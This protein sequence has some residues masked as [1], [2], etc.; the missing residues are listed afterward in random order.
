MG[1]PGPKPIQVDWTEVQALA[2][3]G[4][5]Q[6]EIASLLGVGLRTLQRRKE[7]DVVYGRGIDSMRKSLRHKQFEL[8]MNGDRS[9]LIWLGKQQLNQTDK[10]ESKVEVDMR[11]R[12]TTELIE[13][14]CNGG[15]K[16]V[17]RLSDVQAN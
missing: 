8:A 7:F 3:I 11:V 6:R 5:T 17:N 16:P 12:S 13:S 9:M 2:K 14:G 1:K 10:R 15:F 4:C